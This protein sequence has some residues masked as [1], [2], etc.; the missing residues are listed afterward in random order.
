MLNIFTV[1]TRGC[2][3]TIHVFQGIAYT[4]FTEEDGKNKAQ[5]LIQVMERAGQEAPAKLR[6][7]ADSSMETEKFGRNRRCFLVNHEF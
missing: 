1:I 5:D 2:R 3:C 7:I 4:F 6:E